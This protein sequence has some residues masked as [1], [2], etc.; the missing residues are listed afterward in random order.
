MTV[1]GGEGGLGAQRFAVTK[2]VVGGNE[3]IVMRLDNRDFFRLFLQ[4]GPIDGL[5]EKIHQRLYA[6]NGGKRTPH[7][8][9]AANRLGG[10]LFQQPQS[11]DASEA[12]TD[13]D[14]ILVPQR[15]RTSSGPKPRFELWP[16]RVG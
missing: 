13:D 15:N 2:G 3:R 8:N 5:V 16:K 11:Q 9:Q 12:M 7:Q 10:G 14:R 6:D 4:V 1:A